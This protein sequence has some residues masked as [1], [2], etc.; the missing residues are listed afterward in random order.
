MSGAILTHAWLRAQ[1]YRTA[2]LGVERGPFDLPPVKGAEDLSRKARADRLDPAKQAEAAA[3]R[4]A[5]Q[6]AAG[7]AINLH[8]KTGRP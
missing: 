3:A 8:A 4:K 2:R 6:E 5:D 7:R 1:A